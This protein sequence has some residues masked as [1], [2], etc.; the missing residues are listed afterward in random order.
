[1]HLATLD[2]FPE[3]EQRNTENLLLKVDFFS[4]SGLHTGIEHWILADSTPVFK[5]SSDRCMFVFWKSGVG[6]LVQPA[7]AC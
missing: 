5:L 2:S 6:S 7:S 4:F 1:M 3:T